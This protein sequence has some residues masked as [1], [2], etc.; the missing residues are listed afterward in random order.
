MIAILLFASAASIGPKLVSNSLAL[1]YPPASLLAREEGKVG[2]AVEVS[3]RGKPTKCIVV[4]SS[5]FLQLDEQ[6][7]RQIRRARF[8]PGRDESGKAIS[9]TYRTSLKWKIRL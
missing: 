5:G 8:E 7:C 9:S 1:A 2:V 6:T 3:K 4:A